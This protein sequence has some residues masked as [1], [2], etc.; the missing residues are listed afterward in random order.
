M[1]IR[2][3]DVDV[4]VLFCYF[5]PL[6]LSLRLRGLHVIHTIT[7]KAGSLSVLNRAVLPQSCVEGMKSL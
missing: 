7:C 4:Y 5:K 2:C 3:Y 6:M 1:V